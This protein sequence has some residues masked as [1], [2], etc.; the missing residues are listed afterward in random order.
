MCEILDGVR[1]QHGVDRNPWRFFE[2]EQPVELVVGAAPRR[3]SRRH[4]GGDCS[5]AES[6]ES[7]DG[8]D[9]FVV[10]EASGRV[11][12][13]GGHEIDGRLAEDP[14]RVAGG[15]SI[16]AAA[17]RVGRGPVDPR[18][19]QRNRVGHGDVTAH[20]IDEDG[21]I[22]DHRIEVS[23]VH[24]ATRGHVRFVEGDRNHIS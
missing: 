24:Q 9:Q 16:E 7:L 1:D 15:V 13:D 18:A 6:R 12:D 8:R 4:H 20:S 10:A 19:V 17:R 11:V 23:G 21:A 22:V 14:G 3:C 2:S 5:E